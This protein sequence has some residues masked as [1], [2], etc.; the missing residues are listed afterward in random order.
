MSIRE[1]KDICFNNAHLIRG[2]STLGE[3]Y[4]CVVVGGV[5]FEY[6]VHTT[7]IFNILPSLSHV[8]FL[9]FP[10]VYS[11]MSLFPS[12]FLYITVFSLNGEYV[13]RSFLPD[14]V[15]LPC[16]H[17]LFFLHQLM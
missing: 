17:G 2:H 11:E 5:W 3:K 14:G 9:F 12:I 8:F 16:K 4:N 13:V 10:F 15:F 6:K 7:G 1:S